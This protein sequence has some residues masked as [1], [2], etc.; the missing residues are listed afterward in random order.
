MENKGKKLVE[1][2]KANIEDT[3][4]KI[5]KYAE[6]KGYQ[7]KGD[8]KKEGLI[9]KTLSFFG[10]SEIRFDSKSKS[11]VC[12][13]YLTRI[14]KKICLRISNKFLHFLYKKV[15]KITENVPCLEYSEKELKIKESRK[16]WKIAQLQ[17]DILMKQYKLEKGD[18]Y[19]K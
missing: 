5:K 8:F 1:P 14:D 9:D 11:K 12:R 18:F 19:K 4:E 3:I 15:Y 13:D 10:N 7:I 6:E 16:L 2:T 17:A